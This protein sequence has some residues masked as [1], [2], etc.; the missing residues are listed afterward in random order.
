METFRV[1]VNNNPIPRSISVR[2]LSKTSCLWDGRYLGI[3]RIYIFGFTKC[4]IPAK[5][6]IKDIKN[7]CHGFSIIK[8]FDE[9]N[10][11][12]CMAKMLIVRCFLKILVV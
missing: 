8:I 7:R 4:I 10:A 6:Y 9:D 2:P 11:N 5:M 1:E 12:K 3:I